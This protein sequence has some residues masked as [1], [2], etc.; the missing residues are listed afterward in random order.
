MQVHFFQTDIL[1]KKEER[2]R[3]FQDMEIDFM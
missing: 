1:C 3:G 2:S